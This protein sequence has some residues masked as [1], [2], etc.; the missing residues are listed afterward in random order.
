MNYKCS[1]CQGTGKVTHLIHP[2]MVP[3]P[4]CLGSGRTQ[5]DNARM[6]P[7]PSAF[8]REAYVS[9]QDVTYHSYPNDELQ[10]KGD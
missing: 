3:C 10:L 6:G 2:V 1:Y 4:D 5:F 9:G 8:T 7:G